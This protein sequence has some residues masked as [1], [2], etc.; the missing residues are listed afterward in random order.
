MLPRRRARL[1]LRGR[2][3]K[4]DTS[5]Q[6]TGTGHC[7]EPE[8]PALQDQELRFWPAPASLWAAQVPAPLPGG[9]FDILQPLPGPGPQNT[10]PK[11]RPGQAFQPK[12]TLFRTGLSRPLLPVRP[13]SGMWGMAEQYKPSHFDL[14]RQHMPKYKL[15]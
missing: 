7:P 8:T 9:S 6:G 10:A 11:P 4:G 2:K 5:T 1:G 14:I 15:A 13:A 12:D 3:N